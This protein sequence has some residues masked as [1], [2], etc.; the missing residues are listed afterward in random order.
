[1][2]KQPVESH[3]FRIHCE[4]EEEKL[5]R[6]LAQ[7]TILGVENI[8]YE[9]ITDIKV[10]GTRPQRDP[11]QPK[12]EDFASEWIKKNPTFTVADL[13]R[14]FK[15]SG[16]SQAN[17]HYI[18]RIMTEKGRLRRLAEGHYQ[19]TEIKHIEGPKAKPAKAEKVAAKVAKA[20]VKKTRTRAPNPTPRFETTNRELIEK[21]IKGRKRITA[22]EIREVFASNG[23]NPHSASPIIWHMVKDKS[24][25]QIG[26][27]EYEVLTK[28][29]KAPIAKN[30]TAFLEQERIRSKNY[31]DKQKKQQDAPAPVNIETINTTEEVANG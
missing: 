21:T 14:H 7:L 13:G 25:K 17:A 5:G 12:A 18:A 16:R 4:A 23:R 6:I 29:S 10:F 8:G 1:M 27:G 9:L 11:N 19:S 26:T 3:R 31:R 22:V 2:A 24:L 20:P 15:E 30:H 28:K